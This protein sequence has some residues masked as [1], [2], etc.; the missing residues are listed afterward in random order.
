MQTDIFVS[1]EIEADLI[2]ANTPTSEAAELAPPMPEVV[3]TVATNNAEQPTQP[4]QPTQ[5]VK[6]PMTTKAKKSV[7]KILVNAFD[8]AQEMYFTNAADKKLLRRISQMGQTEHY[9]LDLINREAKG[10][11]DFSDDDRALIKLFKKFQRF[12]ERVPFDEETKEDTVEAMVDY[13]VEEGI[14][15]SPTTTLLITLLGSVTTNFVSLKTL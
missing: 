3:E 9:V 10:E 5:P 2:E 12:A 1:P 14:D 4:A 7:C 6:K 15:F 13:M 8:M 11:T